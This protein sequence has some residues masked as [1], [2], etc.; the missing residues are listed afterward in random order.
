MA[1]ATAT[2]RRCHELGIAHHRRAAGL[3]VSARAGRPPVR[4]EFGGHGDGEAAREA[5]AIM[6]ALKLGLF[7]AGVVVGYLLSRIVNTMLGGFSRASTRRSTSPSPPTARRSRVLLRAGVVVLMVYGGL[8]VLHRRW[9]SRRARRLHS[10]A[11]QGYLVVNAQLP[12]GASLGRTDAVI[13]RLSE[14]ARKTQGVAYTIDLPGYSTLLS[15]NISNVG[16]MFVILEP[17]E[18]RAGKPELEAPGDRQAS[19]QAVRAKSSTPASAVFGAPPVEAWA[20]PAASSCRCRIG[21][22][23]ALRSLQARCRTWPSQGNQD[24][25]SGA[26]SSAASASPSRSS[27][28]RSTAKRPR[29]RASPWTT[30]TKRSRPSS[31]PS[32]STTSPSRTAT[33]RSTCRPIPTTASA[34]RTSERWKSATPTATGCRCARLINVHNTSGPAVVNHYNI[35]PSAEI[36]GG[37]APGVSSG[38]AIA[39]MDQA[40]RRAAALHHGL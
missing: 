7:A 32:T 9:A 3:S 31:A 36:N 6:W 27:S 10:G 28:S 16:G 23:P 29:P 34:W 13:Q 38:Q 12:D 35:Y 40:G 2:P 5:A 15:T 37:T 18:E 30:S 11:G 14:M 17:F 20:A 4:L 1:M 33:G 8:I 25:R 26:A 22:A 24:P 19:A 39:I 21:A